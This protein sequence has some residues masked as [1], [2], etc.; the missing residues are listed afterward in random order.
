[1]NYKIVESM[2][3]TDMLPMFIEAGLEFKRNSPPP[4]GLVSCFEMYSLESNSRIGGA[5]LAYVFDEYVVRTVAVEKKYQGQGLGRKLV[6]H[7]IDKVKSCGGKRVYLNAKVPGFYKKLGFEI[8]R[9]EEAPPISD[10]S[11]CP[12]F[13]NG[14]D[15]EIMK[16]E[17]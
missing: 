12:R 7:V 4:E 3:F 16:L 15:S 9:R 5:S 6:E 1:M 11:N 13:H 2:N 14:C 8:V 17:W 10:C